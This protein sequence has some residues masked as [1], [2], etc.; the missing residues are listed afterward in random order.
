MSMK[1]KRTQM[2]AMSEKAAYIAGLAVGIFTA[3]ALPGLELP[4]TAPD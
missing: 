1:L 2:T 4:S 3:E